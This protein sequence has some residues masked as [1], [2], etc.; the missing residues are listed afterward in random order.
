MANYRDTYFSKN[1]GNYGWYRCV[2]CG[3]SFRKGDVDIDHI[4]PQSRGG[5]DSE[6]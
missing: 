4:I 5:S 6:W 3:R 1:S 2:H